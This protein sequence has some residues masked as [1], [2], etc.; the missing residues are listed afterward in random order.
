MLPV[1]GE[2]PAGFGGEGGGVEVQIEF[3]PEA[4]GFEDEMDMVAALFVVGWEPG[5]V[6][7]TLF[8]VCGTW[9]DL[10]REPL[11]PTKGSL[12]FTMT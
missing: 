12:W 2:I 8:R 6:R 10:G 3:N 7:P 11:D 1:E 5:M 4:R 9:R